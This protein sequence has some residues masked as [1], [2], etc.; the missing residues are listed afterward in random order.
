M[1]L[2][3]C[4]TLWS[5]TTSWNRYFYS[6]TP[7][8]VVY[9]QL[10]LVRFISSKCDFGHSFVPIPQPSRTSSKRAITVRAQLCAFFA[11]GGAALHPHSSRFFCPSG[12]CRCE[13]WFRPPMRE[14]VG[15]SVH[16]L[17]LWR[18][19]HRSFATYGVC[20][21]RFTPRAPSTLPIY[22]GGENR[23]Y[24]PLEVKLITLNQSE[25]QAGMP[26]P[27]G[28]DGTCTVLDSNL[29]LVRKKLY[30][31]LVGCHTDME[32]FP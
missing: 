10:L 12:T 19:A 14:P 8:Q 29:K 24:R 30:S 31:S 4:L 21:R 28:P 22:S 3:E 18:A 23:A 11:G 9:S 15:H 2:T 32:H 27:S 6:I 13:N 25:L 16:L 26:A 7:P 1:L 5:V 20:W 17:G